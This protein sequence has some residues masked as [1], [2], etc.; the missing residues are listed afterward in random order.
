MKLSKVSII[1]EY[2]KKNFILNLVLVVVL[3]VESK[4]L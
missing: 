4:G 1:W 2:A 3:V